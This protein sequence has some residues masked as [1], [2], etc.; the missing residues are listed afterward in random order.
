[1]HE[2]KLLLFKNGQRQK[3]H[4]WRL[5]PLFGALSKN[6]ERNNKCVFIVFKA[7]SEPKHEEKNVLGVFLQKPKKHFFGGKNKIVLKL[8]FQICI[9]A[10]VLYH[11]RK[12]RTNL[13][14]QILIFSPLE[15]FENENF[16]ACAP[17]LAQILD[18]DF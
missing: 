7:D 6:T 15:F 18:L 4:F 3:W 1:M 2:K 10:F 12:Q 14:K 11:K 9:S 13:Y 17:A 8:N 16:D 5:I